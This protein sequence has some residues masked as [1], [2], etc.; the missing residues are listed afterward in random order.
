MTGGS[1]AEEY[2]RRSVLY[3]ERKK[4]RAIYKGS[5]LQTVYQLFWFETIVLGRT[6]V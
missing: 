6:L 5:C 1:I 2:I 3:K 4:K